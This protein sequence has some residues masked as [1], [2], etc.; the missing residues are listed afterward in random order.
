MTHGRDHLTDIAALAAS[1]HITACSGIPISQRV[2]TSGR[3][4]PDPPRAS[5]GA[6]RAMAILGRGYAQGGLARRYALALW[7]QYGHADK[8]T[9]LDLALALTFN[10]AER[11]ALAASWPSWGKGPGANRLAAVGTELVG[12]AVGWY[13]DAS[14]EPGHSGV[15]G[16]L[17]EHGDAAR[18]SIKRMA[19][20]HETRLA[21]ERKAAKLATTKGATR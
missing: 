3:E 18:G 9:P 15:I 12:R 17:L 19:L 7:V 8:L 1:R 10:E 21:R 16:Q 11:L 5:V 13:Q 20:E 14:D 4:S 6:S 2:Q